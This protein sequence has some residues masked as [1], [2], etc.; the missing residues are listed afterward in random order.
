LR[1]GNIPQ[2]VEHTKTKRLTTISK[3]DN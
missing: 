2:V 1:L 3:L